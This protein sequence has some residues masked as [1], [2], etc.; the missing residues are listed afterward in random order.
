MRF[1]KLLF[2][3]LFILIPLVFFYKS[4][5]FGLVPFPGDLLVGNYEPYKSEIPGIP[6]KGQGG[7]VIREL[8][9]WK[10]FSIE[11]LKNGEFPLWNPYVFSGTPHFAS[12]QSG[13]LYPVNII[14]FIMP[15]IPAWTVYIILQYVFLLM[16][17]YLYLRQIKLQKLSS[18][19]GSIA[20][21]FC[22]FLTVWGEYG[23]V[24]H[25]LAFLPLTFFATEK[26]LQKTKWYWYILLIFS[27]TLS[28]LAG[29]IQLTI[30][31]YI[32]LFAYIVARFIS[33]K[34]KNIKTYVLLAFLPF[35]GVALSA[36][37]ILPV[38]DLLGNSLRGNYSYSELV[39][40]LLPIESALTFLVPDFFGNPAT[41]NYFLRGG[42]TLERASH[43]GLWPIIFAFFAVFSRHRFF[44]FFFSISACVMFISCLSIPPIAY[45]Q[46]I[47]IPFLSTGIP[48]RILSVVS[49]C[50]AV[51]AAIGFDYF[52]Y[53]KERKKIFIC[54]LCIVSFIFLSLW[55]AT[56]ILPDPNLLI[57]RRNLILPTGI[58]VLGS[59]SILIRIIPMK[60]SAIIIVA[61]TMFELFYSF[62]KFNSF[63]PQTYIYPQSEIVNKIKSIQG[64]NRT[65]G[66]GNAYIDSEF[67][68]LEKNYTTEGY[69]P[70]FS[71]RYGELLSASENGK[72]MK[73]PP[74][75]VANIYKGYGTNDLKQNFYR[76]RALNLTGTKYVLNK[77]GDKGIDS[78]FDEHD[79]KLIW[80]NN[81]WQIY[82][83]K[84]V[85][86]RYKFFGDYIVESD[87]NKITSLLYSPEF[88]YKDIV[89][90][91]EKILDLSIKSDPSGSVQITSYKPNKI[92]FKTISK[93]DQ[94]LFLS[95]TYSRGWV[96]EI[97][98]KS[99][100]ILPANY[101]YR[102]VPV[103]KGSHEV[104]MYY[105]PQSFRLGL[106]ISSL[107]VICLILCVLFVTLK[108][109]VQK[110]K[111]K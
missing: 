70:L 4:V 74:R 40:R 101:T 102:V 67:Q 55:V 29:Y 95:D 88:S 45:V 21:T 46:S 81:G 48:T 66:Y 16:F 69:N 94:L 5:I 108:P 79:F 53:H 89:I 26:I 34:K 63:V 105:V 65:W 33:S 44:K 6:H 37:Q 56:Y 22:A 10:Y 7:D 71:K 96:A 42:S 99:A 110:H 92:I 80:E 59:L 100:S 39:F 87:R 98:G 52:F 60:F 18:L 28:I 76:R 90:L 50:L 36:V 75:T 41:N 54:I 38:Y 61:L 109:Y 106:I 14:F 51:L 85:L 23:N 27:C 107:I 103:P 32:L 64:I 78:A 83:N 12:L 91:E 72:V 97:D 19:F 25:S 24:G 84:N 58:L 20:F 17:T 68:I 31:M 3:S 49:F 43:I 8:Y 73:A 77:K 11:S 47:G 62:Q 93:E 86:P 104:V 82:E 30:Y 2:S 9:P 111:K 57:S 35:I 1:G 13:T 15:F